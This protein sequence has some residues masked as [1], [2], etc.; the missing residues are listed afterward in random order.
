VQRRHEEVP[1]T[2]RIQNDRGWIDLLPAG[3]EDGSDNRGNTEVK[4]LP[5]K[6]AN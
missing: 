4:T 2:K 6:E 1:E 3:P 5:P